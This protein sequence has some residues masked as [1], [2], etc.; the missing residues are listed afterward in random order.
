MASII[1]TVRLQVRNKHN[2][3]RSKSLFKSGLLNLLYK[4]IDMTEDISVKKM[5]ISM[6]PVRKSVKPSV[7]VSGSWRDIT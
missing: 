1:S 4:F 5:V 7:L 2:A 6:V 3:L